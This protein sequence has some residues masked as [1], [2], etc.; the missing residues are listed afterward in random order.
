MNDLI[1]ALQILA[2]YG[3]PDKPTSCSIGEFKVGIWPE[4]VSKSDIEL[5]ET[6]GFYASSK[7]FWST[8]FGSCFT[9]PQTRAY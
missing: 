5:L 9:W 1:Q 8:R 3:N 6:L 4:D 2:K 7:H